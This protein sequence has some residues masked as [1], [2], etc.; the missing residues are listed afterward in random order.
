[1]SQGKLLPHI[2]TGIANMKPEEAFSFTVR[3]SSAM[4]AGVALLAGG[5]SKSH[6]VRRCSV[7]LIAMMPHTEEAASRTTLADLIG[8]LEVAGTTIWRLVQFQPDGELKAK[9]I[10]LVEFVCPPAAIAI[11]S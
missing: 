1:M 8:L 2:Y 4:I 3:L 10:Q 5:L 6:P 7:E 9:L 11:E